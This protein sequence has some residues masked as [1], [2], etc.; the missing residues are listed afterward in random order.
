MKLKILFFHYK[1]LN[2]FNNT[3]KGRGLSMKSDIYYFSGTGN[4]QKVAMDVCNKLENCELIPISKV[5]KE[6]KHII[7]AE[8]VGFAFPL[9]Y[10]GLPKIVKTFVSNLDF[11]GTNYIFAIVTRAGDVDGI[12]LLQLNDILEQKGKSIDA[13][14]FILMPNNYVL[15]Y[16]PTSPEEQKSRFELAS[17]EAEKIAEIVKNNK[18]HFITT[19]SESKAKSIEKMNLNFHREVNKSDTDFHVDDKCTSCGICGEV[20]PVNN[21]ELVD[22]IPKWQHNCQQCLACINY[23][24]EESIQFGRKTQS[25]GRYHHPEISAGDLMK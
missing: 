20:C 6:E 12:P 4:S 21:I 7:R 18:R 17:K 24:P 16:S 1:I 10:W 23:C 5:W 2:S 14:F 15:G 22:G 8:K 9:Y 25:H 19:V 11:D 3:H 13:G